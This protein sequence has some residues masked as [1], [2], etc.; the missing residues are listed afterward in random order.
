MHDF[1]LALLRSIFGNDAVALYG[2]ALYARVF[3]GFCGH[4]KPLQVHC[5]WIS[6]FIPSPIGKKVGFQAYPLEE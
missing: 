4:D 6:T 5:R 1:T 2:F 3:H